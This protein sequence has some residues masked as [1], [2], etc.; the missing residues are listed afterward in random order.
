MPDKTIIQKPIVK[1]D[2]KNVTLLLEAGTKTW[3]ATYTPKDAAGA[4]IGPEPRVISGNVTQDPGLWAWID[5]V[6][7][8][9]INAQEGTA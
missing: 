3:N 5:T 9:A 8:A 2:L 6:V 4:P 7:V 1:T